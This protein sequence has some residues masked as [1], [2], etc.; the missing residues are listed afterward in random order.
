MQIHLICPFYRRRLLK[1]HIHYLKPTGIM[2]HPVCDPVDIQAFD[3]VAEDWIRPFRLDKLCGVNVRDQDPTLCE[4]ASF[5][6]C[7]DKINR[8]IDAGLMDDDYYGFLDDDSSYE[9]MFFD[10]VRQQSAKILMFSLSR[11]NAIPVDAV[12]RHATHPLIIR[13]SADVRVNNIGLPQYIM[14]GSIL[15]QIRIASWPVW[16]DGLFAETL[17][18]RFHD[19]IQFLPQWFAFGNYFEPGRYTDDSFKLKPNWELPRIV[20]D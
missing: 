6:C 14:R 4:P 18:A 8:F 11:G 5:N 19:E 7:F 3:G 13:S 16:A 20:E 2:W 17:V 15:K 9:P 12:S 10:V 1:T